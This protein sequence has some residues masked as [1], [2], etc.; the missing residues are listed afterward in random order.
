MEYLIPIGLFIAIG[1]LLG[2]AYNDVL[3][4]VIWAGLLGPLGILIFLLI[5]QSKRRKRA[6]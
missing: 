6:D 1:V 5:H 2:R 3:G 4:G